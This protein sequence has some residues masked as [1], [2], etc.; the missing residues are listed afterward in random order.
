MTYTPGVC[1]CLSC[2]YAIL[3]PHQEKFR[4]DYEVEIIIY[5]SEYL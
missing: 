3:T 1:T 4:I 5:N 2:F